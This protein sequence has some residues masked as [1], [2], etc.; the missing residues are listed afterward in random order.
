MASLSIRG[1]LNRNPEI[2]PND[3]DFVIYGNV[4]QGAT[5]F[6][7]MV[8]VWCAVDM[9]VRSEDQRLRSSRP[10]LSTPHSGCSNLYYLYTRVSNL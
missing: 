2:S 10:S 6:M 4:I 8:M 3:L 1:I 5:Y 7:V 9:A